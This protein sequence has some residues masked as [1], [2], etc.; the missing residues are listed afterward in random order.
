MGPAVC[1]KVLSELEAAFTDPFV[2][3]RQCQCERTDKEV[4][5]IEKFHHGPLG[6][7]GT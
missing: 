6:R 5:L 3:D 4:R 7:P 1:V 2:K